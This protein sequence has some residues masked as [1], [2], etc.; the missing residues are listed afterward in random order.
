[1]TEARLGRWT[2]AVLDP[3]RQRTDPV[4]DE[5]VAAI[6]A[7]GQLVEVNRLLTAIL[8]NDDPIPPGIP[9]VARHFFDA[10]ARLPSWADQH[11]TVR[12]QEIFAN[13][14][15]KIT[16]GLFCSSLPQVYCAANAAPVLAQTGALLNRV[17][18][19]IFETAQ[20][21]FDAMGRGG[22][23]AGGRGIR[24]AQ[25]VRL[26]HAAIRRLV[27]HHPEFAFDAA[28][29]GQPINQ[30]DLAGTLLTFSVVT[31]DAAR[32]MEAPLTSADGD[33]WVH[34]WAVVGH[35]LGIE[36]ALL[37]QTFTD[38]EQLMEAFR[39]RQWAPSPT[40]KQLAAALAD[41]MQDLF[42]QEIAHLDGLTP[43]LIRHFAGDR[44]ADLLG[45]PKADWTRLIVD[46]VRDGRRIVHLKD[47]DRRA[48][49]RLGEL[50]IRSMRWITRVERGDKNTPFRL[51]ESLQRSV[52]IDDGG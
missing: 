12:A 1:M 2:A 41:T 34:H 46:A 40:G 44:C 42:T 9:D 28:V 17:R 5:V 27:R 43:T 8:R 25:R 37:P 45:L 18:Q 52:T 21:L 50:A 23:D 49:Q 26:M 36:E 10:T 38:A 48:E 16:F 11:K 19:R 31:F 3:M 13:Y 22:L 39:A 33:A 35:V 30:E 20:F 6:Y 7:S 14:G 24:S 4:A 47:R 29:L 51:P 15:L 32:K